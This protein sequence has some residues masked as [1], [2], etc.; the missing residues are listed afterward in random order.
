[1]VVRLGNRW[2]SRGNSLSYE[3]AYAD[4][5]NTIAR[6]GCTEP[7]I[8]LADERICV[9]QS[10]M[11]RC[12]VE[13][14]EICELQ[15]KAGSLGVADLTSELA[16]CCESP[17]VHIRTGLHGSRRCTSTKLPKFKR[18]AKISLKPRLLVGMEACIQR[19]A[20]V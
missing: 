3:S 16:D 8:V 13:E 7:W 14:Q 20:Q 1:M 11:A 12:R 18:A 5:T 10:S 17:E 15:N 6:V 19:D 9:M 4:E 2:R